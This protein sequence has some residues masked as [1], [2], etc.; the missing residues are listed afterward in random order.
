[1][2]LDYDYDDDDEQMCPTDAREKRPEMER[3]LKR[4]EAGGRRRGYSV[5]AELNPL[6]LCVLVLAQEVHLLHF[7]SFRFSV[8]LRNCWHLVC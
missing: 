4:Q 8:S 3:H 1:M 5:Y 7:V 2:D 6:M